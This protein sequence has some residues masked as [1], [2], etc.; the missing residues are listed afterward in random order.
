VALLR[1]VFR[2]SEQS[3]ARRGGQK[4]ELQARGC[5]AAG[6]KGTNEALVDRAIR[7]TREEADWY[8]QPWPRNAS[9]VMDTR[10]ANGSHQTEQSKCALESALYGMKRPS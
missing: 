10:A 5:L 1:L 3:L 2:K 6:Y 4:R 9:I 7:F 8:G